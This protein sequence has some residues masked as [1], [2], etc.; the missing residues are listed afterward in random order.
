MAWARPSPQYFNDRFDGLTVS[1]DPDNIA[2]FGLL[3]DEYAREIFIAT[4]QE[5]LS[6]KELADECEMSLPTVYR[7]ADELV[8][9]GLVVRNSE[10]D[11][12]G[13]HYTSYEAAIEHIDVDV[14]DGAIDVTLTRSEDAVDRFTRAWEDIRRTG[15]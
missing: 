3:H 6:A 12:S 7:R 10:L 1:D 2:V 13:N 11:P 5:A 9:E 4:T 8:E 15:E 14:Q